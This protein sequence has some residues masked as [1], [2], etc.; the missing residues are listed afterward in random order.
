MATI[1]TFSILVYC[2][3]TVHGALAAFWNR[4]ITSITLLQQLNPRSGIY[5]TAPTA[6]R[7]E[8]A[9]SIESISQTL[10]LAQCARPVNSFCLILDRKERPSIATNF[11]SLCIFLH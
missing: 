1:G 3:P 6:S 8:F 10:S 9:V 5:R 7:L 2:S 11:P 4:R